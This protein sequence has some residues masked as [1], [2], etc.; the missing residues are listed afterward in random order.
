MAEALGWAGINEVPIVVTLYQ[1]SGP[2]TG[3]PTRHG[4]DDLQFA[5]HAGHGDFPR[6]VYASGDIE[7]GFYDTAKCFNFAENF[8]MP[9][10][11]MMDKFIASTVATLNRF[12]PKKIT[13]E[14]GKLLEK[15]ETPDYKRFAPS[16]DG[17]SPRSRLGLENG[18]FWNTGDESDEYGHIS[19]DPVNRITRMDKRASK[20]ELALKTIPKED[21]A[22]NYGVS[23]YCVVS[24]GSTKGPILDA[25][26]MLKKEGLD[27]GFV[28]I[29]LLQP[30]PTDYIKSLLKGAKIIID[31][32]ANQSGQLGSLL[33][34]HLD[35]KVNYY[36]LKYT[37]RPMTCTEIYDS[38]KKIL[39]N[40]AEKKQ[41]LTYGV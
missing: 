15:I 29:K 21:Q 22:V 36:I 19:E 32:E 6:I 5:I 7:E 37:G 39:Q 8:Q 16:P 30:F 26:E 28:Q 20:L 33:N 4:Q 12:D 17:L 2:A 38:L 40:K 18:I 14:R 31:I 10:I 9:V 24:W 27:V 35:S 13:I 25:I 34:E 23:E 41:V 3:L 1:R 11:H